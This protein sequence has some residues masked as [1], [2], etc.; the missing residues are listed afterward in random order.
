MFRK[1]L[2]TVLPI[3]VAL[4]IFLYINQ[5]D[6]KSDNSLLEQ[7]FKEPSELSEKKREPSTEKSVHK[8]LPLKKSTKELESIYLNRLKNILAMEPIDILE[9]DKIMNDLLTSD[10]SRQDKIEGIWGIL[11]EIGFTS[12]KSQYL[13]D[14]LATLLPIELT[15]E[16]IE[17]YSTLD[18]SNI[19]LKIIDILA[20]SVDIANPKLEE[21]RLNFIIKKIG[22]IELF[23]E[24]SIL[25][26]TDK[27]IRIN[28]LSAYSNIADIEDTQAL[29][30][31][32]EESGDRDLLNEREFVTILTQTAISTEETQEEMLPSIVEKMS[33]PTVDSQ[34]RERFN[35]TILDT[36]NA[37]ALTESSKSELATYLKAQEPKLETDRVVS[38]DTISKYYSW[39]EAN[40]KIEENH[41]SLEKI[42]IESKNPI[43][44]S[45]ILLYADKQS[46]QKIKANPHIG[47]TYSRLNLALKDKKIKRENQTIIKD[48]MS[49]LK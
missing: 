45:S 21:S 20:K 29:I 10:I 6:R 36:I 9:L 32:I 25:V 15:D 5:S 33:D 41:I 40:S 13:L 3:A 24:K 48:A 18:N 49:I 43:K 7:N 14:S 34:E 19:K 1:I 47:D 28:A 23:L 27:D 39:A 42:V 26:E 31:Q 22:N 38:T 30:S 8:A 46:I 37:N 2:Y 11:N 16:L 44:V 12:E 35:Q 4:G 17:L